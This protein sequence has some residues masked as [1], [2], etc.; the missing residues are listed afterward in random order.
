MT[1]EDRAL[2][3]SRPQ[4]PADE[5]RPQDV[6]QPEA[7]LTADGVHVEAEDGRDDQHREA[8]TRTA[9][10]DE[11]D[12]QQRRHRGEQWP[13][14]AARD[15][16]NRE[17]EGD[18]AH[19]GQQCSVQISDRRPRARSTGGWYRRGVKPI[20]R[21][22]P[23]RSVA[24][25][26]RLRVLSIIDRLNVGGPALIA[27]VLCEGLDPARFDHRLLAGS[28][29]PDE[30]DYVD[31]RA[32]ELRVERIKGLGRSPHP[33]NDA[34][35]LWRV[36]EVVRDFR[37]HI[38]HTH[39]AKAGVLGRTAAWTR[40]VPATVHQ[41]HGHLLSGYF[42][43]SKTKLVA[44]VER[45]LARPTTGLIAVGAQVR[46]ELLA[47]GIGRRDQYTVVAPGVVLPAP[48]DR[49]AARATFG[50]GP[51]APVVCFV[52]RLT[53]VKRPERFID[54][55]IEV[56]RSHPTTTFL[57]AGEGELLETLRE[58]ARALGDSVQFLGWRGDV[59]TVYAASDVVVLTSD[60]EGMPVALIEAASIGTPAVTTRVGSAPE[61]VLDGVT[62]FVTGMEVASL[63]RA[64]LELLEND[65]LRR[66]MGAAAADRARREF[67]A[68]RL[69]A[70]TAALYERIAAQRGVG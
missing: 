69:V 65:D 16:V 23:I 10:H 26:D 36:S 17:S 6:H 7:V 67:S 59:A 2:P 61:V 14:G 63:V 66:G 4:R 48:P 21:G 35:A 5:R 46:D 56:A 38:V 43:P 13:Q 30:G 3:G 8:G 39:K 37:P 25:V 9:R 15:L 28:I 19:C 64:T 27:T 52:G 12:H 68:A 47:A 31:L 18:R 60:N 57:V 34:Q 33:G 11:A 32:P 1:T 54:L 58:R 20:Q 29:D 51:D 62:G 40:R 49:R 70:D 42:S 22:A 24:S 55:A 45:A 41:F 44:G 53:Q 50:L